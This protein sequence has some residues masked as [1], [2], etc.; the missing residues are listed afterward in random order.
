MRAVW[1]GSVSFGLV[2]IPVALYSA[3][4]REDIKFRQLRAADHSPIS[5]KRV[6][7]ADGKEVPWDQIVKGFEYE[8]GRFVVLREED[9]ERVN[10]EATQ[11]VDILDFVELE[12]IDPVFFQKPYYLEP[13]KGGEKA[14]VLLRDTLKKTGKTGIAKVV[15]KTKQYLA[16]V[17]PKEELLVLELLHFGDE[18]VSA[19]G[20]RVP[21]EQKVAPKEIQTAAALVD[22]LTVDWDPERYSDDYREAVMELIEEK[23]AGG[24]KVAVPA[25]G[26]RPA[27]EVVDL[28]KVLQESL[29]SAKQAEKSGAKPKKK[30][31][32]AKKRPARATRE[33][34]AAKGK[35]KKS[36]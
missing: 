34:T 3:T 32:A 26:K 20:L 35:K 11:T 19:E 13:Q 15:I 4:R 22:S 7:E 28:V 23:L 14:Y 30:E 33:R 2:N 21:R 5:Y 9:F 36:A 29:A 17:K 10:I 27:T 18:I 1:K 12:E 6:A 24:E 25:K 16:A 8:K 31:A